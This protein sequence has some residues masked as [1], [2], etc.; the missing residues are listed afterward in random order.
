MIDVKKLKIQDVSKIARIVKRAFERPPEPF[1][2]V[3][4]ALRRVSLFQD[5]VAAHVTSP[6]DLD[7]LLSFEDFNFYHDLK[8]IRVNLDRNTGKLRNRFRPR[9][10]ARERRPQ[11]GIR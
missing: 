7:R 6:I 11:S 3:V 5:I 2:G 1:K 9:S 4:T 8:G 10:L